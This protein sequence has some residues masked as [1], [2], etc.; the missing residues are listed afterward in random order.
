MVSYKNRVVRLQGDRVVLRA[1]DLADANK[2]YDWATDRELMRL[3]AGQPYEFDF[4]IYLAIYPDGL[5]DP[6][7]IQVAVETLAGE[8]I[9]NCTCYNID[10]RHKEA[11][12]GIVIGKR[13][14]WGKGYGSDAVHF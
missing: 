9:G 2:D 11:E 13:E 10:E 3:D 5:A 12:L 7:K 4:S 14:Y 1:K 8:H 6:N